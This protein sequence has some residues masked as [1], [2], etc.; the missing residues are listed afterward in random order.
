MRIIREGK[1][2]EEKVATVTCGYCACYF[3]F[4]QKEGTS[5]YDQRD[6][7]CVQIACPTCSRY[8]YVSFTQFKEKQKEHI[9]YREKPP[10]EF[11]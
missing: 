3:E 11:S 10:K 6:G 2:P 5:I 9:T 4:A 8:I 7:N 1:L